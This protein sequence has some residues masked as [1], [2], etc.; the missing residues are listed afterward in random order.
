MTIPNI[1]SHTRPGLYFIS[2]NI[3]MVSFFFVTESYSIRNPTC[4][5]SSTLGITGLDSSGCVWFILSDIASATNI[6]AIHTEIVVISISGN[7]N[8]FDLDSRNTT[9]AWIE[10]T[11]NM[12][13]P[14]KL[15]QNS[16]LLKL[17]FIE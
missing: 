12:A 6:T 17:S 4:L 1:S 9:V 14:T 11:M 8:S 10:F 2:S 16:M 15:T 3:L 5:C 13:I 7:L